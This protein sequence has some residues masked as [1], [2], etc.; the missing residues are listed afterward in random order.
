MTKEELQIPAISSLE[1]M[2]TEAQERHCETALR[3]SRC[4]HDCDYCI[5]HSE[6]LEEFL[7]YYRKQQTDIL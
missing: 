7:D 1:V 5:F 3:L 2:G 6:N 4:T